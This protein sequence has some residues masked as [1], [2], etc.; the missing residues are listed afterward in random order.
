VCVCLCYG[1]YHYGVSLILYFGIRCV[2]WEAEASL[3]DLYDYL[4][5]VRDV[6][7]LIIPYF[8]FFL[9]LC[10]LDWFQFTKRWMICPLTSINHSVFSDQLFTSGWR[11][12]LF[13]NKLLLQKRQLNYGW[14]W[15]KINLFEAA[16]LMPS[17]FRLNY[18][19]FQRL[20]SCN[21]WATELKACKRKIWAKA[22]D[23]AF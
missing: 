23:L 4:T 12:N 6:A 21:S 16:T 3:V 22:V 15:S 20:V 17:Q 2:K 5:A 1:I 14:T 11:N 19:K 8:F 7:L 10:Y 18:N 13:N 9:L